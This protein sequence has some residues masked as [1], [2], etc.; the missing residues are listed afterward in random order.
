[1][2]IRAN[3]IS[4]EV[5]SPI[6]RA[7]TRVAI[8]LLLIGV[9]ALSTADSSDQ[10]ALMPLKDG[11][12]WRALSCIRTLEGWLKPDLFTPSKVASDPS[13]DDSPRWNL[14]ANAPQTAPTR[15]QSEAALHAESSCRLP[16]PKTLALSNEARLTI[17]ITEYQA[18]HMP[19]SY[20]MQAGD[21]DDAHIRKL[22]RLGRFNPDAVFFSIC[23]EQ[24]TAQY[25]LAL[26]KL[27]PGAAVAVDNVA[28]VPLL[29]PEKDVVEPGLLFFYE[30]DVWK[31]FGLT[32]SVAG[33]SLRPTKIAAEILRGL[34][35]RR[36]RRA[37]EDDVFFARCPM[38]EAPEP[39]KTAAGYAPLQMSGD[40]LMKDL[41][42]ENLIGAIKRTAFRHM[43]ENKGIAAG[44][45]LLIYAEIL[46]RSL[47]FADAPEI[48]AAVWVWRIEQAQQLL[49]DGLR[50]GADA[51]RMA[52]LVRWM[53]IRYI[54]G[55]PSFKQDLARASH[56]LEIA[57]KLGDIEAKEVLT[58]IKSGAIEICS[59]H[60]AQPY[61]LGNSVPDAN[62]SGP[63]TAL[64]TLQACD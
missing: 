22:R 10:S 46:L 9:S 2:T 62:R 3:A 47:A 60:L 49:H 40:F 16:D 39:E 25:R 58:S 56:L 64:E 61:P 36:L 55:A 43:A 18:R 54:V 32:A 8:T 41:F 38:P 19:A 14:V 59:D 50:A 12:P 26:A 42:A 28:W 48:G 29:S 27:V 1:M 33:R 23:Q 51:H 52:P 30:E 24:S 34:Q 44:S 5:D 57:A 37:E 45:T 53:G 20:T 17:A 31:Y 21:G 6:W 35:S 7:T 4:Q 63:E 15:Q 11:V 13:F